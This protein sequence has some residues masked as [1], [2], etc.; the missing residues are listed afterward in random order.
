MSNTVRQYVIR[1]P[2]PHTITV[3]TAPP[4]A[5]PTVTELLT[6]AATRLPGTRVH[7]ADFAAH[8]SSSGDKNSYIFGTGGWLQYPADQGRASLEKAVRIVADVVIERGFVVLE[9]PD[10]D[11]TVK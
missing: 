6:A 7:P 8:A 3:F 5:P 1:A 4:I 2:D 9:P 11:D 10:I